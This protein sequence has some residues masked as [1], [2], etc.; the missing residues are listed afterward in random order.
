MGNVDNAV[1]LAG[2]LGCETS[3]LPLKYVGLPL[4]APFQDQVLLGWHCIEDGTSS[5]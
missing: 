1:E 4:G 2:L 5:V 3:S